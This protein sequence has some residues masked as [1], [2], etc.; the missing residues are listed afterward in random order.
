MNCGQCVFYTR[1]QQNPANP[2]CSSCTS[3]P[4][5]KGYC[6]AV[7]SVQGFVPVITKIADESRARDIIR[8]GMQN[9]SIFQLLQWSIEE[10]A[11][12]QI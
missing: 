3:D 8:H 5:D 2:P 10:S 9:G 1:R 4:S 12:Q 11:Y 7:A 6:V